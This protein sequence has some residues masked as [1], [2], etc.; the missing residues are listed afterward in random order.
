ML[1][2]ISSS[3][4][5]MSRPANV[6]TGKCRDRQMSRPAN[7]AIG[8]CRDRQMSRPAN[9]ATGRISVG[10]CRDRQMSRPANVATGK[11]R[12]RQM[13]R[14]AKVRPAKVRPARCQSADVAQSH[15]INS[16]V[17]G[18]HPNCEDVTLLFSSILFSGKLTFDFL[19]KRLPIVTLM[20]KA[21]YNFRNHCRDECS[22]HGDG[23]TNS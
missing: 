7:V 20:F 15:T 22:F 19:L 3:D 11:C 10:K 23:Q 6:A 9:V 18:V 8:K 21:F 14:S 5:Q 16:S 2:V 1:N 12:D 4:R 17:A 13:S